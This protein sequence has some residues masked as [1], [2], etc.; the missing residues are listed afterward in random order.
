MQTSEVEDVDF[1]LFIPL[2]LNT[3]GNTLGIEVS[4]SDSLLAFFR[5]DSPLE[6]ESRE[7]LD[8]IC[9]LVLAGCPLGATDL[10]PIPASPLVSL[11][12]A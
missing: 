7:H 9:R 12:A 2:L 5:I 4:A 8:T 3:G 1:F 10:G 6:V 11:L